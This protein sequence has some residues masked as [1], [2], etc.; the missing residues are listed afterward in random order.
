MTE[1]KF[2]VITPDILKSAYT[3][4]E[5]REMTDNL[6][7]ANKTTGENHS[8]T[9]LHYTKMNIHR[10][11]RLDKQIELDPVLE[12][13]LKKIDRKMIW[14]VLTEAWCGDAA[15]LIPLFQ[16]MADT[17]EHIE[18]KLILRDENIELMEQFLFRGKSRSIPKL[19]CLDAES[20]EV[21]GEW[22]PRPVLAQDLYDSVRSIPETPYQ[23]VAERLHK[24]YADDKT[25][26]TQQ[27]FISL[28][29]EWVYSLNLLTISDK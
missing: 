17:N 7:A 9:M 25:E 20:L 21:L 27:E 14:L 4:D 29:R 24:W 2:E 19:I 3:Y 6:L 13:Q 22:G 23:E 12:D 15:Q 26:S 18:L 10:M 11:K 16:K 1:V 28:L 5:Y 8:E